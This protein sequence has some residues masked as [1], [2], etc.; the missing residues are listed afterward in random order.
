M[1][2]NSYFFPSA[3]TGSTTGT[4]SNVNE[5]ELDLDLQPSKPS[6]DTHLDYANNTNIFE[7]P[8]FKQH[9]HLQNCV[10]LIHNYT[11]E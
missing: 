1:W 9:P 6:N 11:V 2:Q 7:I 5:D 3:L 8:A 4:T 10:S